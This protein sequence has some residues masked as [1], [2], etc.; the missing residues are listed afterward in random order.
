MPSQVSAYKPNSFVVSAHN[1]ILPQQTFSITQSYF[2]NVSIVP[3]I[4]LIGGIIFVL[5]FLIS[6]CC[7]CCS[8]RPMRDDS[9]SRSKRLRIYR[10]IF[11]IFL[12]LAMVINGI[13][14][15]TRSSAT[16]ILSDVDNS[17]Q[18]Y[19][20]LL[21]RFHSD[22][23]AIKTHLTKLNATVANSPCTTALHASHVSVS[24]L[25]ESIA[26]TLSTTDSIESSLQVTTLSVQHIFLS[27]YTTLLYNHLR[28]YK[29]IDFWYRT[30]IAHFLVSRY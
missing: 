22:T 21:T 20:S 23:N 19:D 10:I 29:C 9:S 4:I 1:N 27:H 26:E 2:T 25:S 11:I 17:I 7:F 28:V 14:L 12:I 5:A 18:A 16:V 24:D 3:G 30:I 13:M 6:L 8:S 15:M